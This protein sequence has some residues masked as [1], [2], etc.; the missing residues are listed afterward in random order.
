M[1]EVSCPG[2]RAEYH[3]LIDIVEA[4]GT[5]FQ[6]GIAVMGECGKCGESFGIGALIRVEE[7]QEAEE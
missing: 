3:S 7:E 6:A 4:D 5:I 1:A 2:C